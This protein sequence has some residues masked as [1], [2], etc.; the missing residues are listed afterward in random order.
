MSRNLPSMR[1]HVGCGVLVSLVALG[2]A[3]AD[4]YRVRPGDTLGNIASRNG[5]TVDAI[6]AANPRLGPDRALQAGQVIEL[7]SL[8]GGNPKQ[9]PTSLTVKRGDT[10]SGIAGRLGLSQDA[11]L[12]V[13]P[14]LRRPYTLVVGQKLSLP[15]SGRA[16]QAAP[17]GQVKAASFGALSWL[18]PLNGVVTSVFGMREF[19]VFG[20]GRHDG[21]DIAAPVG[22]VVR[23]ARAGVVT[24]ARF[25]NRNGWGGT[26]VV[27]HGGGWT[28][29]YS[30]FS[31][32]L[33]K[34]GQRVAAGG[35]V[36]QVGSTGI[37][38]GPH[39]DY[40]VYQNGKAVDPQKL[41]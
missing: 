40:R 24:E 20:S 19:K 11:I 35:A 21:V 16:A 14:W 12:A 25:D 8:G 23:A 6:R 26:V 9:G 5:T 7:P 33:V 27:D 37:S 31:K 1:R 32:L 15:I 10:L 13:N 18:W 39:L 22:T 3:G 34:P 28:S 4:A 2:S 38:T 30:H 17:N 29:R 41:R 36:G